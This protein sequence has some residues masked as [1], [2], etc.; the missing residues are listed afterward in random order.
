[1]KGHEGRVSAAVRRKLPA[2]IAGLKSILLTTDFSPASLSVMPHVGMLAKQQGSKVYLAHVVPSP[3]CPLTFA[4]I[5]SNKRLWEEKERQI[6]DLSNVAELFDI[7]RESILVHGNIASV[8]SKIVQEREISMVAAVTHG[9]RGLKRFVLGSVAEEIIRT[10][11]CPVLTVGPH[12]HADAPR[13]TTIRHILYPTDLSEHSLAAVQCAL[14]LAR[15]YTAALTILHVGTPQGTESV[16]SLQNLL[17]NEVQKRLGPI[18][19]LSVVPEFAIVSG[20]PANAVLQY[21]RRHGADMIVLGVRKAPAWTAHRLGNIVYKVLA[22]A[23]CPV[24][25]LRGCS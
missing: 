2:E 15:E 11:P 5:E 8:L 19:N 24:L 13:K 21:A 20:E 14:W 12:L 18:S 1:M 23:E 25:T 9:R 16:Q 3:P 6:A 10:C 7:P 22:E 17:R 4:E